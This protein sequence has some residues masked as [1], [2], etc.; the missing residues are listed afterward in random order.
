[1]KKYLMVLVGIWVIAGLSVE[2]L[3]GD[4]II[5]FDDKSAPGFYCGGGKGTKFEIV[6]SPAYNNSAKSLCTKISEDVQQF[7]SVSFATKKPGFY[8]DIS[9]YQEAG[10]SL[11]FYINVLENIGQDFWIEFYNAGKIITTSQKVW[12]S[13][14]VLPDDNPDTWQKVSIPLSALADKPYTQFSGILCRLQRHP[15]KPIYI[16]DIVITNRADSSGVG[17]NIDFGTYKVLVRGSSQGQG[18]RVYL[19]DD[20]K[21]VD[22]N[23]YI[24]L[25]KGTKGHRRVDFVFAW[26]TVEEKINAKIIKGKRI[27]K[28]TFNELGI[29]IKTYIEMS[30]K[31]T[32]YPEGKVSLRYEFLNKG[33]K[34][35][36]EP[37]IH[38]RS[39]Y[40]LLKG[41]EW[42]FQRVKGEEQKSVWAKVPRG[43]R[44]GSK[45]SEPQVIS[46][47]FNTSV[48][49]PISYSLPPE[50][51]LRVRREGNGD[52]SV[53]LYNF[54]HFAATST[55]YDWKPFL[56]NESFVIEAEVILP[57]E[58]GTMKKKTI[59]A[60][61][62]KTKSEVE[63]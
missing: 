34:V 32:F 35:F 58:V 51:H 40:D 60:V 63:L 59:M 48:G 49:K 19:P 24:Y 21:I 2:V 18:P 36:M 52:A 44:T 11:Q 45:H 50:A 22:F 15:S 5:I 54:K 28:K 1:M 61:P 39:G 29:S 4:D 23:P 26:P 6:N 42:R 14:Y 27:Y 46:A 25:P 53:A 7:P 62:D 37:F 8:I 55:K 17:A 38:A 33:D 10:G 20:R 43:L 47:T 13:R 16:D 9:S 30:Y 57:V 3:A 41:E 12:L 31:L 56:K